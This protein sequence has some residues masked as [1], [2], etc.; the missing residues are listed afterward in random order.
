MTLRS[1]LAKWLHRFAEKNA[2]RNIL[3]KPLS[4][5]DERRSCQAVLHGCLPVETAA[6]YFAACSG[7]DPVGAIFGNKPVARR[8]ALSQEKGRVAATRSVSSKIE[9]P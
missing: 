8:T 2:G 7:S 4:Q 6:I 3:Q 5:F 9:L 1:F